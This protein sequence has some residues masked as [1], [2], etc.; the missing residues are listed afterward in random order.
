MGKL[1]G[2]RKCGK[3]KLIK[4]CKRITCHRTCPDKL[5]AVNK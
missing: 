3:S 1:P 5:K 4:M 2:A